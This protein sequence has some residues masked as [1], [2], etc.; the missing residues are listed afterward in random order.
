M[1]N[2]IYIDVEMIVTYMITQSIIK[3]KCR[4]TRNVIQAVIYLFGL[5]KVKA[6]A[7]A[8]FG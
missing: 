8:V 5:L 7:E 1:T 4:G 2:I 3:H 6:K